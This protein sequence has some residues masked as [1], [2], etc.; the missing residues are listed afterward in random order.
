MVQVKESTQNSGLA[1][2]EAAFRARRDDRK[3][4]EPAWLTEKREAAWSAFEKRG[5]PTTRE[6]AFRFT[7]LGPLRN[8]S[9]SP[10]PSQALDGLESLASEQVCT[11][12]LDGPRLV[13]V[14]GYLSAALSR[15]DALPAGVRIVS[16]AEALAAN[17]PLVAEHLD[18]RGKL[19][20]PFYALN[21]AFMTDGALIEISAGTV[22]EEPLQLVFLSSGRLSRN[23]PSTRRGGPL[24][25][26]PRN[27]IIAR[28]G[29]EATVIESHR[30]LQDDV[31]WTN[32]TTEIIL[33]E[34]AGLEHT[35]LGFEQPQAFHTSYTAAYQQNS[36]RYTSNSFTSGGALVRNDID[37]VLDGE[38]CTGTLNGLYMPVDSQLVD[39]HTRIEH[40][41]PNSFSHEL[42]KGILDGRA[43]AVFN[44]RIYVAEDAQK[45]DAKQSNKNM[46]LSKTA[47]V[48]ANPELEIFA[49]DVRCTHGA[50]IGSLEEEQVFYLRSRGIDNETAREI[51][52]YGFASEVI[53][54]VKNVAVRSS[55]DRAFFPGLP[56]GARLN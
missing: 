44:G 20:A 53:G 35:K 31:Y 45:T 1:V 29:S 55:L 47:T 12:D 14:D 28:S 34:N 36:S 37:L 7:S 42:Y 10:A 17:D 38:G 16:L 51:L 40:A 30:G 39:N 49:D 50:T 22:V 4:C 46:L 6:E 5:F 15:L 25:S 27:L 26:S 41:R 18:S 33:E 23:R 9:L 56:Q 13:F 24:F 2:Y 8:A 21:L 3:A 19:E 48:N 52:T 54:M 11:V 43:R 32:V